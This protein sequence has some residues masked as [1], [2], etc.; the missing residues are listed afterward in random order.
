[1]E[2]ADPL[3]VQVRVESETPAELIE[4]VKDHKVVHATREEGEATE[5]E[6]LDRSGPRPDGK[7]SYCYLRVRRA[8]QQYA[9]VSPVWVDWE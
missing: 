2:R 9:W 5:L 7:P 3:L 8:D 4:V 1:M 6:F